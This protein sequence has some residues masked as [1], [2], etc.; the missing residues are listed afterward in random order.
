MILKDSRWILSIF[1]I[2]LFFPLHSLADS[3]NS[4]IELYLN[5]I[6]SDGKER[7]VVEFE[8]KVDESAL[9]GYN[10]KVIRKLNTLN[11]LVCEI[12]RNYIESLKHQEDIINVVTDMV[13]KIPGPINRKKIQES[14]SSLSY[15][16]PVEVRW[17][18]LEE[19]LNSKAAWDR[20]RLSGEGIKIAFIDTGVNYTLPDLT[21]NYLGGIDYVGD[22]NDPITRN[23]DDYHGTEVVSLAV[24]QGVSKVIGVA[25]NAD[26]YAVRVA[27][28]SNKAFMTDVLSGIEWSTERADIISMSLGIYDEE[29]GSDWEYLKPKLRN[30]CNVAY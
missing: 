28:E 19:G 29:G 17:N 12:D 1:F 11:A 10:T 22:D 14:L 30:A 27:D 16:G 25:Y 7:V 2:P 6:H 18:N 20:Y 24:A 9:A 15:T 8:G 5:R 3:K 13:I 4:T 26:F 23:P 21:N